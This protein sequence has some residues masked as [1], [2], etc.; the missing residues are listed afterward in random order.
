MRSFFV[1]ALMLVIAGS[2]SFV[3]GHERQQEKKGAAQTFDTKPTNDQVEVKTDRFSGVTTVSLRPQIILDKPEHQMR[4]RSE[5]KLG[6]KKS[7]EWEMG[8]VATYVWIESH[9][10]RS[11]NYGDRKLAFL[12]D[13][14][15][16]DIGRITGGSPTES[17]LKPGFKIMASFVSIFDRSK[18]EQISN[19]KRIEMR[20]GTIEVMLGEPVVTA[21][22]EYASQVLTLD[23]TTRE[24][25]T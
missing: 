24:K 16:L 2:I 7:H 6:D 10:N 11:V 20:F 1:C 21:L 8:T 13:G 4:I 12:I 14:K 9:Y 5:T 23:K 19:G 3:R 15:P 22:R 17:T 25:K 18:L